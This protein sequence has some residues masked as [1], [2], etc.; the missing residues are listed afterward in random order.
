MAAVSTNQKALGFK[1]PNF[2]LLDVVSN[3]QKS[4]E[5]LKGEKATI[6]MFICNHCPFVVHIQ[7]A[8]VQLANDYLNKKVKFIAIN[9]NNIEKYPDDSPQKMKEV[10]LKLSYPFAYLFDETQDIAKAYDAACTPDFNV[11]D[12]NLLCVYRGQLDDSRPS[13]NLPVSG[14]SIREVLSCLLQNKPLPE[15]QIPSIGCSIKWK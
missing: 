6:V 12:E 4:L 14:S 9:S 11:F 10:A 7:E 1:A 5:E 13:N 15:T 2:T 8:L 3:T